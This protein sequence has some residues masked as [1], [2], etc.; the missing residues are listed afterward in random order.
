MQYLH[1]YYEC[2]WLENYYIDTTNKSSS[3]FP[4]EKTNSNNWLSGPRN[5]NHKGKKLGKESLFK[6][7]KLRALHMCLLCLKSYIL[8]QSG[9]MQL[10]KTIKKDS[11]PKRV[12]PFS[13]VKHKQDE[14]VVS[15]YYI[16]IHKSTI[17]ITTRLAKSTQSTSYPAAKHTN[18]KKCQL[19]QR[20]WCRSWI[21][22]A[23]YLSLLKV[24]IKSFQSKNK[25]ILVRVKLL[26]LQFYP[27]DGHFIVW[28]KAWYFYNN[29]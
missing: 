9:H 14:Q 29:F 18:I 7:E 26:K 10:Q 21:T 28:P 23:F 15:L 24:V 25:M 19:G 6:M 1:R 5:D 13:E 12:T 3:C 27:D 8:D 20:L 16:H 4:D 22:E 17:C 2:H 11:T